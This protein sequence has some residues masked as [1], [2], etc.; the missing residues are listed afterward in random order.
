MEEDLRNF[1]I[2]SP[3]QEQANM[4][5]FE[6]LNYDIGQL[7]VYAEERIPLLSAQQKIVYDFIMHKIDKNEGRVIFL[8]AVAGT[9]KT[10]LLNLI[11]SSVRIEG[12]D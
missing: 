11:L 1:G 9:G 6:E 7:K 10:F 5:L 2:L 3:D 4:H 12:I 8:D